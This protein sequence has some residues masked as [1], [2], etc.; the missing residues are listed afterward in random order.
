MKTD[1]KVESEQFLCY[2]LE[3]NKNMSRSGSAV[4]EF[5][6]PYQINSRSNKTLSGMFK[7]NPIRY[8]SL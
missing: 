7:V 4:L 3:V 6:G 2:H 8:A 5:I 1:V